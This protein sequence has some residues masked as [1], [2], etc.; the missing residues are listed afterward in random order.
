VQFVLAALAQEHDGSIGVQGLP[1]SLVVVV[2]VVIVVV[3]AA[4]DHRHDRVSFPAF[5]LR[6]P[7]LGLGRFVLSS[8]H[9]QSSPSAS[10]RC[11]TSSNCIGNAMQHAHVSRP[12]FEGEMKS[13][14]F[15][16]A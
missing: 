4:I 9:N 8:K 14:M 2:I 1:N 16:F 7:C 3:V 13:Q 15:C 11:D 10:L 6:F 5:A 12:I